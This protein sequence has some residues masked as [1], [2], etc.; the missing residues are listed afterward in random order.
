LTIDEVGLSS[1]TSNT[2]ETVDRSVE[3]IDTRG[4]IPPTL[5]PPNSLDLNHI[6]YVVWRILQDRVYKSQIKDGEELRQCIK[7]Q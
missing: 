6:D 3:E 5:W 7:E 1:G 2:Q 4:F